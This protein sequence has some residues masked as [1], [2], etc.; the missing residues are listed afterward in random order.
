MDNDDYFDL[1][2]LEEIHSLFQELL[3]LSQFYNLNLFR[4]N[5]KSCDFH[6]FI[7]SITELNEFDNPNS[8]DELVTSD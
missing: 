8:D 3:Q 1:K 4:I 2:Y 7:N 6:D 5:N